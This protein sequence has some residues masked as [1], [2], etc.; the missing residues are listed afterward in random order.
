MRKYTGRIF[1][2]DIDWL[3]KKG[4]KLDWLK[5]YHFVQTGEWVSNGKPIGSYQ[6]CDLKGEVIPEYEDCQFSRSRGNTF[7]LESYR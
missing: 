5:T 1:S 7:Y 3:N 6:M 4:F 2:E